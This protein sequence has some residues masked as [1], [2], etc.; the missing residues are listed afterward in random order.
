MLWTLLRRHGRR[1][2]GA[3][4]AVVVLQLLSTL[5]MLYL[6]SLNAR[7]IDEGVARGD[8]ARIWDIGLVMLGVA[9]VQ[10]VAAIAAV[11]FGAKASMGVGRDL[12][13]AVYT[14]VDAFSAEELGRFGAATLIRAAPTTSTRS[15]CSPSWP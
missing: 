5:A 4:A 11:W 12:R 14:R 9:L 10:V 1:Y 2:R 13:R 6:P 3:V 15:R 7:I 8:T